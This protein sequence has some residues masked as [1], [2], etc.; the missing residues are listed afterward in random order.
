METTC[1]QLATTALNAPAPA[2]AGSDEPLTAPALDRPRD[3]TPG[4]DCA[5]D[6]PR[7]AL[8]AILLEALEGRR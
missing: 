7:T 4:D 8:D 1:E 3:G 6:L 5:T 2:D